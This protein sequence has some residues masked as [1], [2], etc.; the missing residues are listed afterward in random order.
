MHTFYL[1]SK[2]NLNF[3]SEV[4]LKIH[5]I[6][7]M[8]HEYNK[9]LL[10]KAF[11]YFWKK[12]KKK[13][14][15]DIRAGCF[16]CSFFVRAKWRLKRINNELCCYDCHANTS[17]CKNKH[18]LLIHTSFIIIDGNIFTEMP[19]RLVQIILCITLAGPPRL[20]LTWSPD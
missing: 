10:G 8:C 16:L 15:S 2:I 11:L 3:K 17:D 1:T 14:L 5:T 7:E 13:N 12:K 20:V 4:G 6:D 19:Q 18:G 9:S